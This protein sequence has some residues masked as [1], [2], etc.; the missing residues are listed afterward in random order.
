M[1]ATALVELRGIR[2]RYGWAGPWVLCG[3]DLS[4]DA[5][6]IVEVAGANG[7]GKSTLLRVLAGATLPCVGRRTVLSALTIGYVPERLTPPP[8]SAADYLRHHARFRGLDRADGERDVAGLAE[9]LRFA[10]LLGERMAAL[11]KGSRQKVA[12]IQALLGRPRMLVL[13]EPFASLDA[14]AGDTLWAVLGER[15]RDGAAVVFSDH[16]EHSWRQADRH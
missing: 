14:E 10:S 9:R 4:V 5:G 13:D 12:A 15:A 8:F 6:A 16:R 1:V 2:K 11:S 7:A 3:I